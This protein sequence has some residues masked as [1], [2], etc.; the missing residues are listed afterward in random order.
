MSQTKMEMNQQKE[1]E[2]EKTTADQKPTQEN[3]PAVKTQSNQVAKKSPVYS[4]IATARD[5][6]EK[7]NEYNM[8]FAREANFALQILEGNKY[9]QGSKPESIRNAIV[10]VSLTGLTLNPAL[11]YAY[12]VPRK[13]GSD[14]HCILD[15]SYI[16]MIKLLTDAGAVK[17]LD[18]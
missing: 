12:L 6:F 5:S 16:G 9:L 18:C 3:V 14:L 15:I 1:K 4:L 11:K 7:A 13:I 8:N 17:S 2:N 10:N